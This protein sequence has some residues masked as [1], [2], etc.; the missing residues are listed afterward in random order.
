[1][2]TANI[3]HRDWNDL[4]LLYSEG[5]LG[6]HNLV[7]R[8]VRRDSLLADQLGNLD[9]ACKEDFEALD[10]RGLPAVLQEVFHVAK[11]FLEELLEVLRHSEPFISV[12]QQTDVDD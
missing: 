2:E 10:L 9:L 11:V 8:E 7:L 3:F 6:R 5:L 1:M 12:G 4:L